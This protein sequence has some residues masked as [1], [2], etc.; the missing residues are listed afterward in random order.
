MA[1]S[2]IFVKVITA[3]VLILASITL[4][5][6]NGWLN[7]LIKDRNLNIDNQMVNDFMDSF[8]ITLNQAIIATNQ[9]YVNNLKN[10]GKFDDNAQVEAMDKTIEYC[11]TMLSPDVLE[12]LTNTYSDVSAFIETN[13][14]AIIGA[15]KQK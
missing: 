12:Y 5:K 13:V 4:N 14:E 11:M 15:S 7:V 8:R 9:T 1:L 10:T 2:E 3:L 6:F